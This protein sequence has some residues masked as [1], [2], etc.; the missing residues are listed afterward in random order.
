MVFDGVDTTFDVVSNKSHEDAILFSASMIVQ[1]RSLCGQA[2]ILLLSLL[3]ALA[4]VAVV[5]ILRLGALQNLMLLV[6]CVNGVIV[7]GND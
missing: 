4:E 5:D 7:S 3:P 2:H 1:T 6:G